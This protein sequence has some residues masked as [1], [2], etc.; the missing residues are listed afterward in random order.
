MRHILLWALLGSCC[1]AGPALSYALSIASQPTPA[2]AASL[3][4]GDTQG[5]QANAATI[6]ETLWVEG[7]PESVIL[8]RY[9]A[10]LAPVS[11]YV[12]RDSFLTETSTN[13]GLVTVRFVA[14]GGNVRNDLAYA[15]VIVPI[16]GG[17]SADRLWQRYTGPGGWL[18]SINASMITDPELQPALKRFGWV[19]AARM[20]RRM[21]QGEL[22]VGEL[23]LG[24]MRGQPFVV[25]V[26]LPA[27]Y[28]EGYGPRVG[29]LL[30]YLQWQPSQPQRSV[31]EGR[32]RFQ[33]I[34]SQFANRRLPSAREKSA[35]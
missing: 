32:G 34:T 28:T 29:L 21:V 26:H 12:V 11:T 33:M 35:F 17:V 3:A 6:T 23:Y 27:E 16:Q 18:S 15:S 31:S 8:D 13:Q 24:E 25:I 20:F 14:N 7:E 19:K 30:R 9:V 5:A 2:I 1:Y 22:M 10:D 4:N